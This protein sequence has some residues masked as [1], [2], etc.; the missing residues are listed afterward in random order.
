MDAV[1][2]NVQRVLGSNDVLTP[3]PSEAQERRVLDSGS[4]LISQLQHQEAR[5][6]QVA[7]LKKASQGL[8]IAA[9]PSSNLMTAAECDQ[10]IDAEMTRRA[11]C[12]RWTTMDRHLQWKL[13]VS[14]ISKLNLANEGRDELSEVR[15]LLQTN[16]LKAVEYD[17]ASQT[18]VRLNHN[19]M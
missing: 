8:P 16:Q 14:Y 2:E 4:S 9:S 3:P 5:K 10:L 13:V 15:K 17:I 12:S 11:R 1:L 19:G 6:Q 18:I 7:A